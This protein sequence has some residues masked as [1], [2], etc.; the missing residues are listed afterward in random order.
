MNESRSDLNFQALLLVI[1]AIQM[2]DLSHIKLHNIK[3]L[4]GQGPK[5]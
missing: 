4:V 2:Y 1:S 5:N 3:L